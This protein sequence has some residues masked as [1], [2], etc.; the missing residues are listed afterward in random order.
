MTNSKRN[1]GEDDLINKDDPIQ[2]LTK[3]F[4]LCKNSA[5]K[6]QVWH[7]NV[8]NM[9]SSIL[10][11]IHC[12]LREICSNYSVVATGGT[13]RE[14]GC[15]IKDYDL[16]IFHIYVIALQFPS[17]LMKFIFAKAI[18]NV[19]SQLDRFRGPMQSVRSET[20]KQVIELIHRT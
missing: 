12:H 2:S 5:T 13:L 6:C 15:E 1:C 11:D 9:Y 20:A 8:S 17:K 18:F 7:I 14:M 16:S 19:W 3:I 4:K 10:L